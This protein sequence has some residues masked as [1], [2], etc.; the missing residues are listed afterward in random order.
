M[1]SY[2]Y[3]NSRLSDYQQENSTLH[4]HEIDEQKIAEV[5]LD[6][7]CLQGALLTAEQDS[8]GGRRSYR[9][10]M[11]PEGSEVHP[12]LGR[13]ERHRLVLHLFSEDSTSFIKTELS[14]LAALLRD[15]GLVAPEPVPDRD[16]ALVVTFGDDDNPTV[17]C[18]L[19]RSTQP[20]PI[21][22]GLSGAL[23][24]A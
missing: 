19:M 10:D 20:R 12:Y 2:I 3:K 9:V 22:L 24:F 5:A 15:T 11:G 17:H 4:R 13:L 14:R 18:V 7:Y 1:A 21:E 23:S 16:G 6:R 8:E